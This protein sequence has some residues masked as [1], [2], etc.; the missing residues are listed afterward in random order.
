MQIEKLR[1]ALNGYEKIT[2]IG[3]DNIDVDAFLSGVLLSNLL[4]SLGILNEFIII[5]EKPKDDETSQIIGELLGISMDEY[6]TKEEDTNRKLVLVDHYET[7]HLGEVIACIDHHP[8]KELKEYPFLYSRVSCATAY[9]IYELMQEAGYELA[10]IEAEAVIVAMMTDTVSFRSGKTVK[11]EVIEAKCLAERYKIDYKKF[12]NYC[13]CLTPIY[14]Y[15]IHE[16]INH[17]YKYYDFKGNIVKSS[18]IQVYG[19][20]SEE[21]IQEWISAIAKLLEKEKLAMW[22]FIIYELRQNNTWQYRISGDGLDINISE[23]IL[24]RGTNIMPEIESLF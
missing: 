15:S 16:I 19:M 10:K 2:I 20:P 13:L 17:G 22:V 3:H 7:H 5:E 23:R 11:E 14:E 8:S 4:R 6:Y 21:S 1:E 9:L 18:Y 24:S 12:E